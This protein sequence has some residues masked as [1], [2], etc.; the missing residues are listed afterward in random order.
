[1]AD[2]IERLGKF[3]RNGHGAEG[4]SGLIKA[5]DH[6]VCEWKKG[7]AGGAGGMEGVLCW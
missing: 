3:D 4:G 5:H 2:R 7:G 6:L 1:M